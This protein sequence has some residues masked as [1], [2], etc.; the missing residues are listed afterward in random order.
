MV[1]CPV[2]FEVHQI[3]HKLRNSILLIKE[4]VKKEAGIVFCDVHPELEVTNYCES[5]QSLICEQCTQ[6]EKHHR[7][8]HSIVSI[9][10]KDIEDY[11]SKLVNKL[12]EFKS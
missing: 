7:H 8:P 2:C 1:K 9:D 6:D 11:C 4:A 3:P 10:D 5:H 12:R